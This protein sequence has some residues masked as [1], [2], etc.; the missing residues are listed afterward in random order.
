MVST[1]TVDS[2]YVKKNKKE[3][4]VFPLYRKYVEKL[5]FEKLK[6]MLI[7]SVQRYFRNET[8]EEK[9]TEHRSLNVWVLTRNSAVRLFVH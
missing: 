8:E 2:Q 6:S 1:L 3:K 7:T 5:K 4:L 9:P